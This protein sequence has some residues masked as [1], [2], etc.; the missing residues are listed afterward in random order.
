MAEDLTEF[1]EWFGRILAGL[2]PSERRRAA[3]KLGQE[4]RRAN[5]QRVADNVEPDGRAMEP[6]KPRLDRSGKIRKRSSGKMFKGLRRLRNWKIDADV[7]G[8]EVRPASGSVDRVSAVS[9]YGEVD[10]V[11]RLRDGRSI[12]YRYPT[13]RILGFSPDDKRIATEIAASLIQPDD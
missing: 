4:L 10:T 7:D 2:S 3:L 9:Q 13:R 5:L 6:R 1:N 12:R 8:V 11:G